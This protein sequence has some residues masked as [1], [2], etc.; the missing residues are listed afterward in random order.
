MDNKNSLQG[1]TPSLAE[2][3]HSHYTDKAPTGSHYKYSG[4]CFYYR[5]ILVKF[6]QRKH[7]PT[8]QTKALL[9]GVYKFLWGPA[10]LTH[11]LQ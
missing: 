6:E 8:N 1:E 7:Q 5:I 11:L 10:N 2:Y 3:L 9:P 4:S